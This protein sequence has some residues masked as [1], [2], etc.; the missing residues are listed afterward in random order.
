MTLA[1]PDVGVDEEAPSDEAALVEYLQARDVACP[2]CGY[3]LRGLTA[4]RCPECG[5]S[6]RLSVGLSEPRIGA[7]VTCLVAV[8]AASGMGVL[9]I[10]SVLRNG[11]DVLFVDETA[12]RTAAI[13]YFLSAAL[14]LVPAL[15]ALRRRYRR[16]SQAVQWSLAGIAI[17]LTALAFVVLVGA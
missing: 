15:I 5:R 12:L 13:W 17:V 8:T 10:L 2:L 9:G 3:N 14:V 6:L 1:E 11:I 16:L 7:W 4:A